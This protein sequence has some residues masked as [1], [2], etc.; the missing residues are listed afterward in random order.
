MGGIIDWLDVSSSL[1]DSLREQ[2]ASF[3]LA[4]RHLS[5]D[6]LTELLKNALK[7]RSV[8]FGIAKE[9]YIKDLEGQPQFRTLRLKNI[10]PF[11][12][13]AAKSKSPN[14]LTVLVYPQSE[15][16]QVIRAI[17]PNDVWLIRGSWYLAFQRSSTYHLLRKR[18]IPY[19]FHSPFK[20][21]DEAK[22][23]L[24]TVGRSGDEVDMF[25]LVKK[26]AKQSYDY[27]YQTGAVLAEELA[28]KTFK[29][30]DSACNEVVPFQTYALHHGNSR[31]DN[32]LEAH[33]TSHYDTIHAEMNLMMRA[34]KYRYPLEG[35]TLFINLLPC[36]DC[37]RVLTKS[38][39]K[40]I[41]YKQDHSDGY[42]ARLCEMAGIKVVQYQNNIDKGAK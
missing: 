27:S 20:D 42:G 1:K 14:G 36:P 32:N 38:G 7:Q 3:I 33:D 22:L 8:I 35:K 9:D 34:I 4:P 11:V 31:E 15:V 41:I 13:R 17:R 18:K 26:A 40:E 2:Q 5:D 25:E 21:E 19:S 10:E 30:I 23:Y 37:A 16:D 29:Y 24:E 12:K 6:R 39:L 28:D